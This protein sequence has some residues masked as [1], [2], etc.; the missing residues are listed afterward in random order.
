MEKMEFKRADA[1]N[2]RMGLNNKDCENPKYWCRI[3]EVWL[4]EEDVEEKGCRRK[5]TADM[6]GTRIC[7]S[8]EK[9][10]YKSKKDRR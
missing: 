6:L 10:E 8:L 1:R 4:S 9:R 2:P 3:H 7:G 5:M